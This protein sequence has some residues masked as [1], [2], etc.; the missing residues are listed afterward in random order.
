M[1]TEPTDWRGV[2]AVLLAGIA[3]AAHVGKMPPALPLVRAELDLGLVAVGWLLSL[4]AL[5]GALSGSAVGGVVD[6]F[7][8][9][10][11]LIF[12]L[13][14]TTLGSLTGALLAEGP[15]LLLACRALEGVGLVSVIASAPALIWR[16]SQAKDHRLAFGLWSTWMPVGAAAMMALSPWLLGAFGWRANWLSAG[17]FTLLALGMALI[18]V[19]PDA[20]AALRPQRA[21]L[22]DVL[23]L[24]GPWILGAVFCSYSMSFQTVFGFLPSYLIGQQHLDSSLAARLT[25]L[26]ILVNVAGNLSAGWLIRMGLARWQ[27]IAAGCL[28]MAGSGWGIF[29]DGLPLAVRYAL[30]LTFSATGGVIPAA[31]FIAVPS[32]APT[33]RHV[34]T[35]GG[36]IVQGLSLG[37]LAGP[38]T[39]AFLV[40]RAGGWHVAPVFLSVLAGLGIALSLALGHLENR[41]R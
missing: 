35:I 28:I 37:Q 14:C 27:L 41:R 15:R 31:V 10:R 3:M 38:P 6:R 1:R 12:G 16:D 7:G 5:I 33:P 36:L 18:F 40:E 8:Q 24:P 19:A 13:G 20:P 30:C 25:A 29:S 11:A 23:K 32:F 34:A 2:V 21:G 17:L 22:L 9:R 39:L 26:A 4:F